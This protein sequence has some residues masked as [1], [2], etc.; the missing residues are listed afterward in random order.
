MSQQPQQLDIAVNGVQIAAFK[1]ENPMSTQ[2]P[3]FFAHANGFHARVWDQVI[4]RLPDFTAYALD[5]RGHGRSGKPAEPPE[6]RYFADDAAAVMKA[7]NLSGVIGVGHSIGGHALTAAAAKH[8]GL[9]AALLLIDPVIMPRE[10]YGGVREEEH[11][12]TKRR[13]EWYSP[14][15][16][17]ERFKDR[18]PFDRW[19]AQVLHDYVDYGLIAKPNG[20]YRLACEPAFEAAVYNHSTAADIYPLLPQVNIPVTIL[21]AGGQMDSSIS[22]LAASPTAPDLAAHFPHARDV[23]LPQY[24]H[25]I[26]M[27]APELVTDYV[28]QIAEQQ[29]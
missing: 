11:F 15:E 16:M 17:F 6:W 19:Q 14:D 10:N 2:P 25:F 24:S 3:L 27:E 29:S 23:H 21:R 22:N 28:R 13:A 5:M 12:T 9:F 7:L 4:A 1:W 26:P 8:P 18:P 20:V